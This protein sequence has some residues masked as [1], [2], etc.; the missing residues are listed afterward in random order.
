MFPGLSSFH[1]RRPRGARGI[2]LA[3]S[4][5]SPAFCSSR[6]IRSSEYCA[7]IVDSAFAFGSFWLWKPAQRCRP[8][9]SWGWSQRRLP[10]AFRL[11]DSCLLGGFWVAH[12]CLSVWVGLDGQ[13][14]CRSSDAPLFEAL[15][16]HL[17]SIPRFHWQITNSFCRFLWFGY[18][19]NC[20]SSLAQQV[21]SA[22]SWSRSRAERSKSAVFLLSLD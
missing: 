8:A 19:T 18:R 21:G 9:C 6:R 22:R 1:W 12:C 3:L 13:V 4:L 10:L 5:S 7:G 17:C 20:R 16:E 2:C 14:A 15:E 11:T